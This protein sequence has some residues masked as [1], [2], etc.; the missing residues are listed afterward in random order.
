MDGLDTSIVKLSFSNV[1]FILYSM[2]TLF[3]VPEFMLS[4]NLLGLGRTDFQSFSRPA[5]VLN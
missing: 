5:L 4:T 3:M 2:M 1:V